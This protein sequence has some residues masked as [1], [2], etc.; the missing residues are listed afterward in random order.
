MSLILFLRPGETCVRMSLR[1][2][3]ACTKPSY[4]MR[5]FLNWECLRVIIFSSLISADGWD[6][7]YRR[8]MHF[9]G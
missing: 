5:I 2:L 1:R 7:L 6:F 8:L 3:F 9:L 4:L